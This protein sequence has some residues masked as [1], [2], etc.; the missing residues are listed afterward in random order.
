MSQSAATIGV[1][2]RS[3]RSSSARSKSLAIDSPNDGM[4]SL[5]RDQLYI[6]VI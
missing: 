3:H 2:T 5:Y 4:R 1:G 6:L